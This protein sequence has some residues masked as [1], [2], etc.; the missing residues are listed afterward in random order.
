MHLRRLFALSLLSCAA[1][2]AHAQ[3]TTIDFSTLL[4]YANYDPLPQT[5]GDH[6]NLDVT[7]TTRGG[8]GN[9]GAVC[10]NISLWGPGY[11]TLAGAGFACGNG[12]Y[13]ELFFKPGAGKQVTLDQFYVGAYHPDL[14]M[15]IKVFDT[16]WNEM[17]TFTGVINATQ[18]IAPNVTSSEGLFL[19]WGSEWNTG[20]NLVQTTVS[21]DQNDTPPTTVTP[22]PASLV[23]VASGFGVIAMV[24]RRKRGVAI[25]S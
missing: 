7:N 10:P 17:F 1:T 6:S 4:P 16:G 2:V 9:T 11:S 3:T 15:H 20:L 8:F 21:D 22:E 13:G 19:Q 24:R 5:F 23:L 14:T 25:E 18:L 12:Q